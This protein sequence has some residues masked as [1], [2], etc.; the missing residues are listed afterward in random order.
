MEGVQSPITSMALRRRIKSQPFQVDTATGLRPEHLPTDADPRQ[1]DGTIPPPAA[2]PETD[3]VA[4]VEPGIARVESVAR[5]LGRHL[6]L[7]LPTGDLSILKPVPELTPEPGTAQHST[8]TRIQDLLDAHLGSVIRYLDVGGARKANR[9]ATGYKL[10]M[11][12]AQE[13]LRLALA[14]QQGAEQAARTAKAQADKALEEAA[15][16]APMSSA[17]PHAFSP[18]QRSQDRLNASVR[19]G[20][21]RDFVR[22]QEHIHLAKSGYGVAREPPGRPCSR[23]DS[24]ACGRPRLFSLHLRGVQGVCGP[25]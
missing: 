13:A 25:S 16:C 19:R 10:E 21:Q 3:I 7:A 6:T 15:R 11:K 8:Y 4:D 14:R 9:R 1:E 23:A 18:P 22:M 17:D 12:E 2:T 24:Q 5:E 20:L